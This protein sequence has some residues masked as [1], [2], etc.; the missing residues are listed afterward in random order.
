MSKPIGLK[1]EELRVN[2]GFTQNQIATYLVCD[3]TYVSRLEKGEREFS[4]EMLTKLCDLFG[5]TIDD[6]I[7]D[8]KV[9][10]SV[11]IAFRANRLHD[12]D[13]HAIASI[14][15]MITHLRFMDEIEIR[16]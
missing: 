3:Q 2:A 10:D 5:C 8:T 7:N 1:M 4:I 16:R 12:D 13:L 15:R 14:N 6:V 9:L 11:Q